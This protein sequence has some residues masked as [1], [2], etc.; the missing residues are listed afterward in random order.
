MRLHHNNVL[1]Q[2][3]F[4]FH[5]ERIKNS[6][7][8]SPFTITFFGFLSEI[9]IVLKNVYW[10]IKLNFNGLVLSFMMSCCWNIV[11]TFLNVVPI[12]IHLIELTCSHRFKNIRDFPIILE[13]IFFDFFEDSIHY[14]KV[15]RLNLKEIWW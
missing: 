8:W 15:K 12:V 7:L 1:F 10:R 11:F 14:R 5:Q 9:Y 13:I 4:K 6:F 3:F 2:S